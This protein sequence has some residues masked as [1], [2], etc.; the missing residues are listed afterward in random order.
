MRK[1]NETVKSFIVKRAEAGLKIQ[2]YLAKIFKLSKREAKSL[3]DGH[4][5]WINRK[6]IWM[7][8][9]TVQQGDVIEARLT[10][11]KSKSEKLEAMKKEPAKK[12]RILVDSGSYMVVDKPAGIL[13]VGGKSAESMLREQLANDGIMVVHRLDRDTSG[14]LL[15]AKDEHA[16]NAAV[17]SF[18]TRKVTKIYQAVVAGYYERSSSTVRNELDGERAVTHI[19]KLIATKDASFLKIRI[20]TG[21][22]HQIRRH[23]MQ[24]HYPI[25]GDAEYGLKRISDSRMLSLPRQMLHASSIELADPLDPKQTIKAHSPLP[26]DLRRCLRLFG[27]GK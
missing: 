22:T 26:A 3:L 13:S 25:L 16:F 27:M 4:R 6:L 17:S 5:I 21:R 24:L 2:D 18:K 9:H 15:V 23:L 14:C 11:V 7:A 10:G 19:Q 8:H 12:L 1:T 20:E